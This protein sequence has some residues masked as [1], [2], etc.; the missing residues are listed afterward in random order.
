MSSLI[1]TQSH[2]LL[3]YLTKQAT[4]AIREPLL[5]KGLRCHYIYGSVEDYITFVFV[6]LHTQHQDFVA[7]MYPFTIKLLYNEIA[8]GREISSLSNIRYIRVLKTIRYKRNW[9]G[10][11]G[12][13][14]STGFSLSDFVIMLGFTFQNLITSETKHY[15]LLIIHF[16]IMCTFTGGTSIP[17]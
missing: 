2:Q 8:G 3:Q 6:P 14:S 12:N 10:W 9:Y 5:L 11:K 15:M 4:L 16:V 1:L 13:T 7:V 17:T